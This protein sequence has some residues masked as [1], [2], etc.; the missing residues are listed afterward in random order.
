MSVPDYVIIGR[1]TQNL[2]ASAIPVLVAVSPSL[3]RLIAYSTSSG[4]V[5]GVVISHLSSV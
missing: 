1:A 2:S 3:S 5:L 4:D